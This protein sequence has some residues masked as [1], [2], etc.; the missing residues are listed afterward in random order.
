MNKE[1]WDIKGPGPACAACSHMFTDGEKILSRLDRGPEGYRRTDFCSAC[2]G[3][4]HRQ[5]ALSVWTCT[6][7]P[8]TPVRPTLA[9]REVAES[10]LRRLIQQSDTA[11]PEVTFVLAIMLERKKVLVEKEVRQR[12]SLKIRV[13]EHRR[14]GEVFIIPDPQLT[15]DRVESV[16][17]R[18]TV[19]LEEEAAR[20]AAAPEGQHPTSPT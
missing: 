7:R 10:L 12:D 14:T 6:Y 16:G 4:E 13:Y 2:A 3:D 15:I 18:V 9:P 8:P 19:L 5:N 17:Q 20:L 11:D 1:D